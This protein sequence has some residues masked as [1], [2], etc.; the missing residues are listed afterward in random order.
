[1]RFG[2][3]LFV[4]D[5][6]RRGAVFAHLKMKGGKIE[7]SPEKTIE[8]TEDGGK[9]PLTPDKGEKILI[10]VRDEFFE[11]FRFELPPASPKELKPLMAHRCKQ[12][13][14]PNVLVGAK[15]AG[16]IEDVRGLPKEK[17]IVGR[18]PR[19]KVE[20]IISSLDLR[21]NRF[22]GVVPRSE[23]ILASLDMVGEK[24]DGGDEPF[25]ALGILPATL[26]FHFFL[27]REFLFSRHIMIQEGVSIED[28]AN[29]VVVE[30]VQ[31]NLY[32]NQRYRAEC[33]KV[34]LA[35]GDREEGPFFEMVKEGIGK[36][37]VG[38]CTKAASR[39]GKIPSAGELLVGSGFRVLSMKPYE[40]LM[41][42]PPEIKQFYQASQ[43][44]TMALTVAGTVLVAS[45]LWGMGMSRNLSQLKRKEWELKNRVLEEKGRVKV[46]KKAFP[47]FE[48]WKALKGLGEV[49]PGSPPIQE[50]LAVLSGAMVPQIALSSCQV[51]PQKDGIEVKIE[52]EVRSETSYLDALTKGRVFKEN[53]KRG[54][55]EVWSSAETKSFNIAPQEVSNQGSRR[56]GR[57]IEH[58]AGVKRYIMELSAEF[59]L[60]GGK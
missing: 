8:I 42:L 19:E 34:F 29:R 32:M 58:P 60:R 7:L 17:L 10:S 46:M 57:K 56:R 40:R 20:R 26:A 5:V 14:L 16:R 22:M 24:V 53:L 3:R 21:R 39:F 35:A 1:M 15:L 43:A 52:G 37:V 33:N 9:L 55:S 13:A 23:L 49:N 30:F 31:S 48:Q 54:F 2:K 27:G 25:C 47:T 50:V 51:T 28:V 45:V 18:V 11:F 36:E 59:L 6:G 44:S 12:H 4:V 38:L 41:I